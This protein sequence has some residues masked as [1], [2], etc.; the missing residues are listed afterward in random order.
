MSVSNRLARKDSVI[1]SRKQ[2]S[3]GDKVWVRGAD[4]V[5]CPICGLQVKLLK[6]KNPHFGITEP[7]KMG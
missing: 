5:S 6:A 3:G 7:H 1:T 2:C 4:E